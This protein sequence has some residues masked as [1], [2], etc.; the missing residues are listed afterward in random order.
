MATVADAH[1]GLRRIPLGGQHRRAAAGRPADPDRPPAPPGIILKVN[2]VSGSP[3]A[4]INLLTDP[5]IFGYDPTTGQLIRFDLNLTTDTGAVDPTFTPITCRRS[6]RRRRQPGLEWETARC[7]GQLRN[8]GL[9]LQR[10]HR[11]ARSARSPRRVPINSIASTDTLTVLGSYQT[12]QLFVINLTASLQTGTAQPAA[13][14]PLPFTPPR[15]VHAPG[16][17][18]QLARQQ[19]RLCHGGRSPR[20][21]PTQPDTARLSRPS[22][23]PRSRP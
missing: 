2:R 22:A 23:P 16:R 18:H 20:Y 12:N 17:P 3:K 19:R 10:D 1:G 15:S 8:D 21:D 7:S 9:R 6:G 5:K 11:R 14:N 4:P 13:G